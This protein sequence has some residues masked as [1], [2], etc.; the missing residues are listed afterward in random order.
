MTQA[1]KQ[2]TKRRLRYGA[3]IPTDLAEG[4]NDLKLKLACRPIEADL[5]HFCKSYIEDLL[6]HSLLKGEISEYKIK[7]VNNYLGQFDIQITT[8][9][10][11]NIDKLEVKVDFKVSLE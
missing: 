1:D 8:T 5:L 6:E 4:L 9:E 11:I 3:H 10:K 2:L 7:V